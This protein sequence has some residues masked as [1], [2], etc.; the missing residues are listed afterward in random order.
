MR[1][2]TGAH[3]ASQGARHHGQQQ[4]HQGSFP[5][6]YVEHLNYFPWTGLSCQHRAI[7]PAAPVNC[8]NHGS[9][10]LA[11]LGLSH[12]IYFTMSIMRI[13][14]RLSCLHWHIPPAALR[15]SHLHHG[16]HACKTQAVTLALG[17]SCLQHLRCQTCMRLS[18]LQHLGCHACSMPATVDCSAGSRH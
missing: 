15:L 9:I 8:H 4:D 11:A 16:Y 14:P 6:R 1:L 2:G 18:Q 13:A 10:S 3:A 17:I 12:C 5:M 7:V